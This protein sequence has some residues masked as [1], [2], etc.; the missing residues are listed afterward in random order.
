VADLD[1]IKNALKAAPIPDKLVDDLFAHFAELKKNFLMGAY[2]SSAIGQFVETMVDIFVHLEGGSSTGRRPGVDDYL[3]HLDSRTTILPDPLKIEAS[4]LLRS[5]YT[6]RNKRLCHALGVE[7]GAMDSSC[8]VAC[9]QWALGELIRVKAT[10]SSD[11]ANNAIQSIIAPMGGVIEDFGEFKTVLSDC[12]VRDEMLLLFSCYTDWIK[13]DRLKADMKRVKEGTVGSTLK[14]LYDQKLV[15][16]KQGSYK[17]T[18]KGFD[19]AASAYV[20]VMTP[21]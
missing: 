7:P 6:L 9:A 14:R 16:K 5:C 3:K 18:G 10:L 21:K 13:P 15:E 8:A 12:T 2:Y 11:D 4:R 1:T 19:K 17:L 20:K